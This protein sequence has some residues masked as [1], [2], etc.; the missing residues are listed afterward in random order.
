V[1]DSVLSEGKCTIMD[2][3]IFHMVPAIIVINPMN[4]D[5]MN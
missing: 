1:T 3:N 5:I 2:K 4:A